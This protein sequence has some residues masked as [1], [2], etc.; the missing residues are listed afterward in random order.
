MIG[1]YC[2][3][4]EGCDPLCPHCNELLLYAHERLD[5]CPFGEQKKSCKQCAIHCYKATMRNRMREVMRYAGPRMIL[6]APLEFIK[7]YLLKQ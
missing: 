5:K 3:K 6:Y 2:K 4:R 7:H 1:I